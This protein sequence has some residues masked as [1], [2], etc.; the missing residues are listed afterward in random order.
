MLIEEVAVE[1]I[2]EK[3]E[4][5]GAVGAAGTAFCDLGNRTSE[6]ACSFEEELIS[7]FKA[8]GEEVAEVI[9]GK[10]ELKKVNDTSARQES[11]GP[12]EG[13]MSRRG[14]LEDAVCAEKKEE[15]KQVDAIIRRWK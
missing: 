14:C 3:G 6:D 8:E 12:A 11:P 2:E 4:G 9:A 13:R 10:K 5:L 1:G 7:P 15:K